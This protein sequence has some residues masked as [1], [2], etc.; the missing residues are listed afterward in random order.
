MNKIINKISEAT[1][2]DEDIVKL[3]LNE[4]KSFSTKSIIKVSS[5]RDILELVQDI[6]SKEVEHLKLITLNSQKNVI[7]NYLISKGSV[8][9]SLFDPKEIGRILINDNATFFV[10]AHN[11]PSGVLKP[12]SDDIN[13]TVKLTEIGEMLNAILLDHLI[14]N[15]YN[16][17]S[18]KELGLTNEHY[19]ENQMEIGGR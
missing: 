15:D 10:L 9:S 4:Y 2:I 1:E 13:I 5:P 12:S 8:N 16:F 14:V 18:F 17:L 7:S 11:H 19:F 3:I 6:S